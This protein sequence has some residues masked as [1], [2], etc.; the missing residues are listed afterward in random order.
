MVIGDTGECIELEVIDE[1]GEHL[2]DK[3]LD[4]LL[5]KGKRFPTSRCT[6]DQQG[7]EEVDEVDP[8]FSDLSL[9]TVII[10]NVHR[11]GGIDLLFHL[12]ERLCIFEVCLQF[13]VYLHDQ[14]KE[15]ES[16]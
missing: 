3:L 7:P 12:L 4:D 2:S 11:I 8:A 5:K 6:D 14:R 9:E 15:N 10:G 1:Q 13:V 16:L